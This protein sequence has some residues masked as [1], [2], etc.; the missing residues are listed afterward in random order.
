M[1]RSSTSQH[2]KDELLLTGTNQTKNQNNTNTSSSSHLRNSKSINNF[3][4][5][6]NNKVSTIKEFTKKNILQ[7]H[8]SNKKNNSNHPPPNLSS[9]SSSNISYINID[10]DKASL[11]H[12]S[13]GTNPNNNDDNTNISDIEITNITIIPTT[14]PNEKATAT[15]STGTENVTSHPKKLNYNNNNN[16]N[17]NSKKHNNNNIK[18]NR[19]I[20]KRNNNLTKSTSEIENTI[21][22][23]DRYS[24]EY[25]FLIQLL[26]IPNDNLIVKNAIQHRIS[27]LQEYVD[28]TRRYTKLSKSSKLKKSIIIQAITLFLTLI[29]LFNTSFFLSSDDQNNSNSN[30][31]ES[32]DNTE[33][34]YDQ[35][36]KLY[37]LKLLGFVLLFYNGN[38]L[39]FQLNRFISKRRMCYHC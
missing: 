17:N 38:V 30:N 27:Y 32:N 37:L 33:Y 25:D 26:S 36:R 29:V 24:P 4:N 9:N 5:Y 31:N 39:F 28:E 6:I 12:N 22:N 3:N 23:S 21:F 11:L 18:K 10:D 35:Q 1:S 34:T 2:T 7:I 8:N 13:S 20:L 19:H 14:S 16:N 15:M